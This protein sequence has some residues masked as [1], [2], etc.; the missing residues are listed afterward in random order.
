M[1][2][3]IPEEAR[4]I[5]HEVEE[6]PVHDW[7]PFWEKIYLP[8]ETKGTLL[9]YVLFVQESANKLP[10][11]TLQLAFCISKVILLYGPPGNGKTKLARGL[12]NKAAAELSMRSN[13]KIVY[14]EL[15]A[16]KLSSR[17]LG[18]SP[19]MVQRAFR[20]IKEIAEQADVVF[21]VIDEVES[22]LTNRALTLS[23]ANPVDVFK[24]VNAVLQEVDNL[25]QSGSNVFVIATSNLPKAIE[26]AFFD[27]ADLKVFIDSPSAKERKI[28]I[29]DTLEEV[30]RLFGIPLDADECAWKLAIATN[31]FS[32]RQCRKIFTEAIC[33]SRSLAV[34]PSKLSFLDLANAAEKI[35]ERLERDRMSDG[36]YEYILKKGD[37]IDKNITARHN[38][39]DRR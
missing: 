24:S 35:R 32:A 21:F 25:I 20:Y 3:N 11:A 12:A 30:N 29:K 15:N 6:I 2:V 7:T 10:I 13:L 8:L 1:K 18:G 22:L 34:D 4:E 33:S 26:L 9:N 39:P 28:I 37:S 31:G 36:V 19:Q 23:E 14:A 5:F 17:W 38:V 27:R 16:H